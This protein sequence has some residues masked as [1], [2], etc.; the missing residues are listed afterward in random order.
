[1]SR[2]M[3]LF[4][5]SGSAFARR[6]AIEGGDGKMI[7]APGT[8]ESLEKYLTFAPNG[9]NAQATRDLLAGMGAGRK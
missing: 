7:P 5:A 8:V 2:W 6:P 9:A 3:T 1:M 4:L